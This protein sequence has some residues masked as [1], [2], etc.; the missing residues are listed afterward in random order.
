[1]WVVWNLILVHLEIVL[2]S[3]QGWSMVCIEH[4]IGIE[5][6]LDELDPT[7]C[8]EAQVEALFDLF[9]DS[10][11]LDARLV[12]GLRRTYRWL[13]NSIGASRWNSEVTWVMWNLVSICFDTVLASVQDRCLVC[14]KRT[15]G[16]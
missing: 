7:T 4:N 13:K 2:V 5:I 6:V 1:M 16:S 12:N 11:S 14:V 15:I 10:D 9:G 8:D 3:V